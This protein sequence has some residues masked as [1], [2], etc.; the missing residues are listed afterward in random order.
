[1]PI[2]CSGRIFWFRKREAIGLHD[3]GKELLTYRLAETSMKGRGIFAEDG[4]LT[5]LASPIAGGRYRSF[6]LFTLATSLVVEYSKQDLSWCEFGFTFC[7]VQSWSTKLTK[8]LGYDTM[9]TRSW[10]LHQCC[11]LLWLHPV[12]PSQESIWCIN[13]LSVSHLHRLQL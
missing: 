9:K 1:M 6:M 13:P 4:N 5:V 11:P 10:C 8:I 2:N 12:A 7:V 3:D